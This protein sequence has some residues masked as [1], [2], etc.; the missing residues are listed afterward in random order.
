M[1]ILKTGKVI[2]KIALGSF[3]ALMIYFLIKD[4][5]G[6][7]EVPQ[8]Y[9]AIKEGCSVQKYILMDCLMISYFVVGIILLFLRLKRDL[10]WILLYASPLLILII[11]TQV[12]MWLDPE[13][14]NRY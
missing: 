3:Y 1:Q 2:L 10:L 11:D 14:S 12:R 6:V 13:W 9:I 8:N 4:I 7:R 5:E